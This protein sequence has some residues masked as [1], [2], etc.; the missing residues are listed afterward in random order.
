MSRK[1]N[2]KRDRERKKPNATFPAKFGMGNPVRVKAGTTDPDFTD[3]PLGGWA[4]TISEVDQRSNP[5]TYLIEWNQYTLDHMHPVFRNRCERDDL[6]FESMW[7]AENDL[8]L[9]TGGPVVIEQPT[10]I[11]TR[12]LSQNDQEDRIRAIFALT[13]NDPLPQANLE[14]L[15]RYARHL[16]THLSFPFQAKYLVASAPSS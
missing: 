6:T 9:D 1:K 16:K 13:S 11:V 12:P 5:P 15:R 10:Q 14:N 3:I 2:K 4:G 8:E 7:L